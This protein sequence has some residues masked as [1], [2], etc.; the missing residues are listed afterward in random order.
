MTSTPDRT[1]CGIRM[2]ALICSDVFSAGPELAGV[3]GGFW[4]G[5][6]CADKGNKSP[7]L[8]SEVGVRCTSQISGLTPITERWKRERGVRGR[9]P[10][11]R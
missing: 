1:E 8:S 11:R 10:R 9:G 6:N 3:P 7:Q 4:N 5:T 2:T